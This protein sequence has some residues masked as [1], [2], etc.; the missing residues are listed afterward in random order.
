MTDPVTWLNAALGGRYRI[1]REVGDGRG[2]SRRGASLRSAGTTSVVLLS[3]CSFFASIGTPSAPCPSTPGEQIVSLLST[4]RAREKL[5]QLLV[6]TRLARAAQAHA[7]DMASLG[8]SGHEGS[9]GSLPAA[10]ADRVSYPWT[11]VAENTSAGQSTARTLRC[12]PRRRISR[13]TRTA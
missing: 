4:T 9:D 7:E 3:G 1:E 10:R 2:R 13:S 12:R 8:Y 6:D 11:F 5:P